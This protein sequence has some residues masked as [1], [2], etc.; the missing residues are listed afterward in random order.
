MGRVLQYLTNYLF[1]DQSKLP[2]VLR[3]YRDA[4]TSD[5]KH[6]I[7]TVVAELLPILFVRPPDVGELPSADRQADLDGSCAKLASCSSPSYAL[8]ACK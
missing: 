2:A 5:I 1:L 3:T 8:F 7:K 6:T 4:L